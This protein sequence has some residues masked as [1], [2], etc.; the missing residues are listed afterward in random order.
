M[1]TEQKRASEELLGLLN[2]AIA[3]ELQ[4]STQY[5]WQHVLAM[6]IKGHAVKGEFKKIAIVEMKHAEAIAERIHYLG[7]RPTTQA[8]PI[9]VGDTLKGMIEQDKRD[10]EKAIDLYK[11][12]LDQA[13][14]E[15]DPVTKKL[16]EDILA[17]EQEH[18]HTFESL[19]VDL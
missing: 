15:S 2:K 13:E 10:E 17:D 7:G 14:K 18:H 9:V 16:F 6:G 5:M 1:P 12:I 11:N 8:T 4:T 19:L 3:N